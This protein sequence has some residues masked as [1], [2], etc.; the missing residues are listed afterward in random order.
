MLAKNVIICGTPGTGKSTLVDKIKPFLSS[1]DFINLS[2]FAIDNG[3]ISFYDERLETSVIDE[4]I[5]IDKLETVLAKSPRPA[6][7]ECIHGDMLP[8]E[9]VHQVFVCQTN[10]TIL[11]DRLSERNYS[12]FKLTKNIEAEIFES[13]LSEAHETFD[14]KIV[15]ALK[16]DDMTDLEKNVETILNKITSLQ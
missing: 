3:C 8:E 6:I 2:K 4:E 11:Y 12:E 16:N 15:T 7:I 5:L 13:S 1:H 10:N 14:S 9:W